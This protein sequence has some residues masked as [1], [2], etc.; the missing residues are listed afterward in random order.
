MARPAQVR[1]FSLRLALGQLKVQLSQPQEYLVVL[2]I[3]PQILLQLAQPKGVV[4]R[5][6]GGETN[7]R[8]VC[9]HG[10]GSGGSR[11]VARHSRAHR[12]HEGC[13]QYRHDPCR[14]GGAAP[15]PVTPRRR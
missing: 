1:A 8:R 7:R 6:R 4:P 15:R 2:V 13:Q 11:P 3:S 14:R 5:F 9:A 12:D 10:F